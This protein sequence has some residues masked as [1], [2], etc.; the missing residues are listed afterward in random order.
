MIKNW[1][2]FFSQTGSEID[3]IIRST[4][5]YPKMIVTN[6]D[7]LGATCLEKYKE[8]VPFY[9]LSK[10]P[11]EEEYERALQL[12][13]NTLITLHG[14]LRIIPKKICD[15]FKIYNGH[16]GDIISYPEL[17]G[18]NPQEKAFNLKLPSSGSVI[19]EATADV[20]EGKIILSKQVSIESLSLDRIYGVLHKNSVELW[21]QFLQERL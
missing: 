14:Y 4:N 12:E 8:Y 16:P 6:R 5:F 20:D 17:K 18:F 9:F 3:Q 13:E 7:T 19:H 11:S 2:C 15:R 1:I 21:C 10:K